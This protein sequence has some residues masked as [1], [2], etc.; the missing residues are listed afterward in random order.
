[1]II[2]ITR[3]NFELARQKLLNENIVVSGDQG[4]ITGDGVTLKF[5]YDG[6][7]FLQIDVVHKPFYMPESMIENEIKKWFSFE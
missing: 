7:D 1:M 6:I 3:A 4:I 2:A 5:A